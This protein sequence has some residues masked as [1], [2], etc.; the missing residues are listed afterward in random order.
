M[1]PVIE[2][3]LEKLNT[4]RLRFTQ[5]PILIGGIAMEYYGIRK[6]GADIDLVICDEDYQALA[7]AYPEKRKDIWGDLGVVIDEL[8]IWRGIMLLDYAF[9]RENAVDEGELLVASP[10]RLLLMRVFAMD[11]PKYKKDL[12]LIRDYYAKTYINAQYMAEQAKHIQ[13]YQKNDGVVW[14]GMYE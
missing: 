9:Y 4:H 14:G 6:A 7:T 11:N 10:D 3:A 12:E 1:N 13:T 8:E 5:K 2:K